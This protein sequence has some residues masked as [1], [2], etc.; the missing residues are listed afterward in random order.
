[1]ESMKLHE[2]K[3]EKVRKELYKTETEFLR[4]R[5]IGLT[6]KSF[7]SL[8]VIGRGG[9]GEVHLVK[10]KGTHDLFAMKKLKKSEMIRRGKIL[11]SFEKMRVEFQYL[12]NNQFLGEI[13]NARAERDALA[14]S[15]KNAWVVT[16]HFSFQDKDYLYLIMEYVPGGDM[17]NLLMKLGSSPYTFLPPP[18]KQHSKQ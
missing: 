1:M 3:R 6:Y 8:A 9:F 18:Q 2:S 12:N 10:M 17:M 11:K 4:S 7:E 13:A 16:L 15:N 14:E 5:R